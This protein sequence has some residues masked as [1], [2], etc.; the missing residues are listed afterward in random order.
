MTTVTTTAADTSSPTGGSGGDSA[1]SS[2]DDGGLS[3]SAVIGIGVGVGVAAIL[4]LAGVILLLRRRRRLLRGPGPTA[5]DLDEKKA[6][7][8]P[9]SSPPSGPGLA[10]AGRYEAD[11]RPMK[12]PGKLRSELAGGFGL[13]KGRNGRGGSSRRNGPSEL[14]TDT[15]AG[16]DGTAELPANTG[17][18]CDGAAELSAHS[19]RARPSARDSAVP[20][21]LQI[22][23][24]NEALPEDPLPAGAGLPPLQSQAGGLAHSAPD[25]PRVAPSVKPWG[26]QWRRA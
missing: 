17:V 9:P 10:G 2:S 15:G 21:P 16:R 14:P 18:G 3:N 12:E 13:G 22:R 7:G 11:G 6:A 20:A 4:L 24:N 1:G 26:A 8:M 23:H 5:S 25:Q 19:A